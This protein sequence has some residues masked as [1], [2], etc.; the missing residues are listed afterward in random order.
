M[1]E[2]TRQ[3]VE[4]PGC[5]HCCKDGFLAVLGHELRN[6]LAS[7]HYGVRLLDLQTQGNPEASKNKGND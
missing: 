6:P 4:E 7:I 5:I 3:P 1:N 2:V